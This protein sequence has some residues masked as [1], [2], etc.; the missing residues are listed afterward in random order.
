MQFL[1]LRRVHD[2]A[3]GSVGVLYSTQNLVFIHRL[4]SSSIAQQQSSID[5]HGE[6]QRQLVQPVTTSIMMTQTWWLL[7]KLLW[8]TL[9]SHQSYDTDSPQRTVHTRIRCNSDSKSRFLA[10]TKEAKT[11]VPSWWAHVLWIEGD[12]TIPIFKD[13]IYEM[14]FRMSRSR[15]QRV[16]KDVMNAHHPF[17]T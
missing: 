12:L 1:S 3:S 8:T 10:F 17:Y 5:Y 2:I 11:F 14:M 4:L 13:R 16:F 15:M 9:G 6:W 7:F